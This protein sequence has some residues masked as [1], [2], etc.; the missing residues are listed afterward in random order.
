M[1]KECKI[2]RR[3][4]DYWC[5]PHSSEGVCE[6]LE[7]PQVVWAASA[8]FLSGIATSPLPHFPGAACRLHLRSDAPVGLPVAWR[9]NRV[10][11]SLLSPPVACV[12]LLQEIERKRAGQHDH[13]RPFHSAELAQVQSSP[14]QSSLE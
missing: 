12:L 6:T 3:L 14:V 11:D 2:E 7:D 4:V 10:I 13:S 9:L 5:P 1:Q 8:H